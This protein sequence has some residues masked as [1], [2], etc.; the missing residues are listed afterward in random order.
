MFSPARGQRTSHDCV[1]RGGSCRLWGHH[2]VLVRQVHYNNICLE[3]LVSTLFKLSDHTPRLLSSSMWMVTE[4]RMT[5]WGISRY[6]GRVTDCSSPRTGQTRGSSWLSIRRISEN[7]LN[8]W[9]FRRMTLRVRES[10]AVSGVLVIK[11]N[12]NIGQ[13]WD[14]TQQND[15]KTRIS[16][17]LSGEAYWQTSQLSVTVIS[18]PS[19]MLESKSSSNTGQS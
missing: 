6:S 10:Q 4:W 11:C 8:I 15:K 13:F 3:F 12:A 2:W 5:L 19:Y 1:Q 9:S 18:K 14:K 17:V 16:L 7:K